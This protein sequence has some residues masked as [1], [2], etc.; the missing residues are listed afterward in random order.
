MS[1][2]RPN[3]IAP[4]AF[5]IAD[6][7][8]PAGTERP[9]RDFHTEVRENQDLTFICTEDNICYLGEIIRDTLDDSFPLLVV[10]FKHSDELVISDQYSEWLLDFNRLGRC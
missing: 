4:T 8:A 10:H 2:A 5:R 7:D 3:I 6:F 9:Y 1:C